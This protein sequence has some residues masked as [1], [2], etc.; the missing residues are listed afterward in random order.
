MAKGICILRQVVDPLGRIRVT[1]RRVERDAATFVLEPMDRFALEQG[2]RLRERGQLTELLGLAVGPLRTQTAVRAGLALGLDRGTLIDAEYDLSP[3]EAAGM[4]GVEVESEEPAV[5]LLGGR[6]G[7]WDST[8]LG[9]ALAEV[10]GWPHVDWVTELTMQGD[11]VLAT[12]EGEE[13]MEVLDLPLPVVVTTQQGVGEPRRPSL[14]GVVAAAGK[15]VRMKVHPSVG[16]GKKEGGV[17]LRVLSEELYVPERL[18][19]T[20]TGD[21]QEVAME[22]LGRL[23]RDPRL[24]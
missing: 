19:V 15:E 3:I 12:H 2:L 16:G 22:L 21:P 14:A 24:S 17:R 6:E 1:G 23:R 9:P 11:R 8:A 20:L 4:L 13:G 10:L 7:E 18:G 5:V